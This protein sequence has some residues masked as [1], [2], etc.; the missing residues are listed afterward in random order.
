MMINSRSGLAC[1]H[2]IEASNAGIIDSL[3]RN[4]IKVK[5]YNNGEKPY[6]VA[7][8]DRIAQGIIFELPIVEVKEVLEISA[9]TR[10]A[11]GFGSSG[12]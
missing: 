6:V 1:N 9:S 8:G 12:K 10:G 7:K 5:L 3:Y 4:E 2:G 11:N